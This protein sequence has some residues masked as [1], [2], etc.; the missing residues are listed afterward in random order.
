MPKILFIGP[1]GWLVANTKTKRKN[2]ENSEKSAIKTSKMKISKNEKNPFFPISIKI[3]F[4]K[5]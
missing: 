4:S 1:M 2:S 3:T 5:N